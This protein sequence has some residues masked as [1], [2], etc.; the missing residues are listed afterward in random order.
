MEKNMHKFG[1]FIFILVIG[2]LAG[3]ATVGHKEF[4]EQVAPTK[5]NPAEIVMVFEYEN[6]DLKEIYEL[7]FNDFLI[8]GKSGFNGPYE[9]PSQSISYAKSIGADVFITSSQFKETR[10]SFMNL[11]TPTTSTTYLSGYSGSGS[12]YG[13]ATTYGTKTTTIPVSVNRYDQ[14]GLYLRNVNN[15]TPLWER[16]SS[17][18]K[19]TETSSISGVWFN[20]NYEI[21]IYR[22]G[23]Q[24]VAFINS[25]PNDRDMWKIDELKMIFGEES[26]AGVYLMGNKTPMPAKIAVNKFGHLEVKLLLEKNSFS[27]ARR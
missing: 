24:M 22:S 9:D 10:I 6:V 26:G 20:E 27:F 11:S 2:L 18:Y 25:M 4:Y 13:S 19:E 16:R 23:N 3:C 5:Y 14:D 15:I 8:I 17:D 7:L 21:K 1:G 12:F